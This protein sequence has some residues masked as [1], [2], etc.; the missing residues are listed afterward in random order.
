MSVLAGGKK[1]PLRPILPEKLDPKIERDLIWMW[2]EIARFVNQNQMEN[3]FQ[4]AGLQVYAYGAALRIFTG[5]IA[6]KYA[7][8]IDMAEFRAYF[9]AKGTTFPTSVDL[10]LVTE[11]GTFAPNGT[12]SLQVEGIYADKEGADYTFVSANEGRWWIDWR[13]YDPI[14][15]W[16][17]WYSGDSTPSNVTFYLDVVSDG[18]VDTAPPAGW[19]VRVVAESATSFFIEVDRP[20]SYSKRITGVAYQFRDSTAGSLRALDANAGASVVHYDGSAVNHTYDPIACTITKASGNYGDA[21][22]YGGLLIADVRASSF[23][24]QYT[25]WMYLLP[26]QFDGVTITGVKRLLPQFAMVGGKYLNVRL[27]IVAPLSTWVTEG[28]SGAQG[29][30]QQLLWQT[31]DNGGDISSTIFRSKS[32]ALPAGMVMA[33][34]KGRVFFTNNYSTSDDNTEGGLGTSRLGSNPNPNGDGFNFNVFDG[35]NWIFLRGNPVA[36]SYAFNNGSL[37]LSGNNNY[38]NLSPDYCV[39]P[40]GVRSRGR[41]YPDIVLGDLTI[42]ASFNNYTIGRDLPGGNAAQWLGIYIIPEYAKMVMGSGQEFFF[43]GMA[44]PGANNQMGVFRACSLSMGN[45]STLD[46][47]TDLLTKAYTVANNNQ[48]FTVRLMFRGGASYG[49]YGKVT[50]LCNVSLVSTFGNNTW[51][52]NNN[53]TSSMWYSHYMSLVGYRIFLG[54][55]PNRFSGVAT[56]RLSNFQLVTGRFY[57]DFNGGVW[58]VNAPPPPNQSGVFV[59]GGG[60]IRYI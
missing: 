23:D 11:K 8:N 38:N 13:L 9:L 15:G 19:A 41:F 22:T 25:N 35:D 21:A 6:E 51:D 60:R 27:K 24:K 56:G 7:G 53:S 5:V 31:L 17:N 34:L 20:T 42:E 45:S 50:K 44:S 3:G 55:V 47:A 59:S 36:T 49:V 57:P 10:R 29:I 26:E 32:F 12:T 48:D 16:S 18:L 1:L 14:E 4:A 54:S 40:T 30:D 46:G 33:N 39:D 28:Y 2:E 58:T 52:F 37:L 43:V